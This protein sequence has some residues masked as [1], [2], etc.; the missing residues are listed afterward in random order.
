MI[1]KIIG[2]A[3]VIILFGLTFFLGVMITHDPRETAMVMGAMTGVYT[4]YVLMGILIGSVES[5]ISGSK[6][7][8]N[9]VLIW[10]LL[11]VFYLI[12]GLIFASVVVWDNVRKRILLLITF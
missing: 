1:K 10:P 5:K 2:G 4:I 8:E 6:F 12:S 7:D 11:L 9:V 3:M